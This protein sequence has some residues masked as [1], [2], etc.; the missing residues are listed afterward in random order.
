M[1][2]LVDTSVWSQA[3]RRHAHADPGVIEE[4]RTLISARLARIIGPIRQEILSGVRELEQFEKLRRHLAAFPDLPIETED[5]VEAAELFNTCRSKGIQG[6]NTDFLICAIALRREMSIFTADRDFERF[7]K[8]I[9][10]VL[11]EMR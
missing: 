3:L 8:H 9:P 7:A 6:S 2:V 11:H 5:Y 10:I 4:L 1:K